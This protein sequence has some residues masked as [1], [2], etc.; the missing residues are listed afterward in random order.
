VPDE[1]N[2]RSVLRNFFRRVLQFVKKGVGLSTPWGPK[3]L[4]TIGFK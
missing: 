4:E 1:D 2:V 3:N